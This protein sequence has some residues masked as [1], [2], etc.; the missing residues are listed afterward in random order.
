VAATLD[1]IHMGCGNVYTTAFDLMKATKIGHYDGG[2]TADITI[3]NKTVPLGGSAYLDVESIV[4]PFATADQSKR[5][6]WYKRAV[7]VK[8]PIF[9]G[10]C[11]RVTTM[12]ELSEIARRHGGTVR[13]KATIRTPPEGPPAK[14]WEA[15]YP[16]AGT[17]D[18]WE[19][20]KPT[21][22]CWEDRLYMHPSGPP[23]VNAPGLVDP[24][25]VAWME[26]GGTKAEMRLWLDQNPDDFHMKFNGKSPGL[27]AIGVSTDVGEVV[28]RRPS[29]TGV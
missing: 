6:W 18:P 4:D 3:G 9:S 28:I 10:V 26:M 5:P 8:S 16:A 24:M 12:E 22:C 29:A 20:G 25:G 2:F 7:A 27:Y 17:A 23:V 19:S 11:L 21:W 13:P 14:F 1:H 15:P